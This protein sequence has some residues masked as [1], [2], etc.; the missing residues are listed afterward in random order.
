MIGKQS[1]EIKVE[2]DKYYLHRKQQYPD[3]GEQLDAIWKYINHCSKD[4][5]IPQDVLEMLNTIM[6]IKREIPKHAS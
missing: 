3:V 1:M 4:K 5:D 6:E 2:G